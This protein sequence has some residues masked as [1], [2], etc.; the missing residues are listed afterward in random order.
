MKKPAYYRYIIRALP[1][2]GRK[3]PLTFGAFGIRTGS[4]G[5]DFHSFIANETT[6]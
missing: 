4:P 5:G 1:L 6:D 3:R 2:S